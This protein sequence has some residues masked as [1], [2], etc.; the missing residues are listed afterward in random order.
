M[1]HL[2][3]NAGNTQRDPVEL[4]LALINHLDRQSGAG[5]DFA[6]LMAAQ[7]ENR[8][9]CPFCQYIWSNEGTGSLRFTVI[10]IHPVSEGDHNVDVPSMIDDAVWSDRNRGHRYSR[11][12]PNPTCNR[13]FRDKGNYTCQ[14]PSRLLALNTV[15]PV[16][17]G[18]PLGVSLSPR[19]TA[20]PFRIPHRLTW[21]DNEWFSPNRRHQLQWTI[22]GAV[23]KA[24]TMQ[25][26]GHYVALIHVNDL[27]FSVDDLRV[28]RI[29]GTASAFEGGS[30]PVLLLY[31]RTARTTEDQ[32]S[33]LGRM[34]RGKSKRKRK[35]GNQI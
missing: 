12:C 22:V 34:E 14:A 3:D 33:P 25:S 6:S 26:S 20:K 29:G 16:E 19:I 15:W 13:E 1:Q 23:I 30:V 31:E 32:V 8:S 24:G 17:T 7:V 11:L 28:S 21:G 9:T 35:C 2:D 27:W 18:N 5:N 10:P 4:L